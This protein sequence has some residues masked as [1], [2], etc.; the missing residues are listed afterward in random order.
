[1]KK[2]LFKVCLCLCALAFAFNSGD[3]RPA[4]AADKKETAPDE[5]PLPAKGFA[6]TLEG[7]VISKDDTGTAFVLKVENVK[8][9]ARYAK[10]NKAKKPDALK[11]KKV[12]IHVRWFPVKD[13]KTYAPG[14]DYVRY[15][16]G[17]KIDSK[18]EIDVYSDA[19]N[20]LI[21]VEAPKE[22]ASKG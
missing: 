10:W 12:L 7:K 16:K 5:I 11:G 2:N 19:W 1:M 3:R 20:R 18:T 13:T 22:S 21:M 9:V 6:G 8:T 15:V 17:L 4:S 14:E